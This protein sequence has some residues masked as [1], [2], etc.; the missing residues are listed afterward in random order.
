MEGEETVQYEIFCYEVSPQAG[1]APPQVTQSVNQ[2]DNVGVVA[3]WEME[4]ERTDGALCDNSTILSF[5]SSFIYI[6]Y[7]FRPKIFT[8]T[9]DADVW[10]GRG[11]AALERCGARKCRDVCLF[12]AEH[13]GGDQELS[14]DTSR[15]M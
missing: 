14:L 1:R 3:G 13:G 5:D 15:P 8:F 4:R 11:C 7:I 9:G 12:G 10:G 6:L 2:G